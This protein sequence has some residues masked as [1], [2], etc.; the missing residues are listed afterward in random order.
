MDEDEGALLGG[1]RFC[2]RGLLISQG[3][4]RVITLG[5]ICVL[6]FLGVVTAFGLVP[7]ATNGAFN[8]YAAWVA[9]L[10]VEL[11]IFRA[12]ARRDRVG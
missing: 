8:A 7:S 1:V 2:M 4:T 3:R 9:A 10:L 6:L 5:N 11:L 12:F